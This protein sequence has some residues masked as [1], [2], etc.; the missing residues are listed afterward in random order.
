MSDVFGASFYFLALLNPRDAAHDRAVAASRALPGR[1]VTTE[2]ILVEVADALSSPR[3]RPRFLALL[4][5]LTADPDTTIAPA[6]ADRFRRG[7]AL[8]RTRADKD[9]PL[10]DC[11]SF[12]VMDEL[13]LS[14][15]LTGDR[16]FLQAGFRPLLAGPG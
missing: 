5:A 3:D 11:L 1:L 9:W 16:H 7:I 12:V 8:Y 6:D 13:G 2:Y 4:D 10:T 14:E 15:A